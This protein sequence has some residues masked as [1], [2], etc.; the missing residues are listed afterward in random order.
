MSLFR[1]RVPGLLLLGLAVFLAVALWGYAPADPPRASAYPRSTQYANYCGV[2]GAY[3]SSSLFYGLGFLAYGLLAGLLVEAV[4]LLRGRIENQLF[5]RFAGFLF[6]LT[7]LAGL[8]SL[9][10]PFSPGT[11]AG[12]GGYLGVM[13]KYLLASHF[14]T[15]GAGLI[16]GSMVFAGI[17]LAF[18][19]ALLKGLLFVARLMERQAPSR[20]VLP[21]QPAEPLPCAPDPRIHR[22]PKREFRPQQAVYA[23]FDEEIDEVAAALRAHS[24]W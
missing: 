6:L 8:A 2:Y 20:A 13:A 14:T 19:I 21:T 22:E 1:N 4:R 23:G 12:P 24:R 9:F 3:V 7:G 5:L 10:V 17:I 18:D 16:L 15:P 11:P